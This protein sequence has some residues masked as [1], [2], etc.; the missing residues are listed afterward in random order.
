MKPDR[1]SLA[2]M[3]VG[4][5]AALLPADRTSWAAAMKTEVDAI[6]DTDAALVFAAGCVWGSLKERALTMNFA[7]R[8]VRFVVIGTMLALALAAAVIAQRVAD[9]HAP[10]AFVFGLTSM[11]FGAAGLWSLLRG[12]LALIRTASMMIPIY[13]MA[14]IIVQSTRASSDTW[15]NADLYRALAIEGVVIWA[16]LLAGGVFIL[17]AGTP[18]INRQT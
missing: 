15:V 1:R 11:L 4:W 16:A 10:S 8:M 18:S 13:I 6:E 12:P 17:R 9:V 14:F 5:C 2:L 3:I 7:A